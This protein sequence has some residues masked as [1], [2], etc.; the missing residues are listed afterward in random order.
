M[1]PPRFVVPL[2]LE[3]IRERLKSAFEAQEDLIRRKTPT[4]LRGSF[5]GL[6]QFWIQVPDPH[7]SNQWNDALLAA[8]QIP[9]VL[10]PAGPGEVAVE[11]GLR[12]KPRSLAALAA[13]AVASALLG[14]ALLAALGVIGPSDPVRVLRRPVGLLGGA[15]ACALLATFG[16][17]ISG[18]ADPTPARLALL[19]AIG[20]FG[21][22]RSSKRP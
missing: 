1:P 21:A 7:R 11:L 16:A 17:W 5:T 4:G 10:E 12:R 8:P 6:D 9:C 3:E 22:G 20:L 15:L 19:R 18:R 14:L 13:G 2:P